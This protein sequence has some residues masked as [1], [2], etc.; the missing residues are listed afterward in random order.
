MSVGCVR[1]ERAAIST[2]ARIS[3]K[4]FERART[5]VRME[6]EPLQEAYRKMGWL[7]VFGSSGTVRVIATCVRAL[8]P[9][10]PHITLDNLHELAERVIAAGHVDELDLPASTQNGHR[11]FRPASRS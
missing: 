2:T 4:R 11:C 10:A 7:Q 5:A 3:E 6:I 1:F 9:D 8:N